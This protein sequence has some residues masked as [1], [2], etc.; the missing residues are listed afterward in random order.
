MLTLLHIYSLIRQRR[1][2]QDSDDH[3]SDIKPWAIFLGRFLSGHRDLYSPHLIQ[4]V[5]S[6]AAAAF[7]I[8]IL[9]FYMFA[10][11]ILPI[12]EN[13]LVPVKAYRTGNQLV[14]NPGMQKPVLSIIAV[15]NS[16]PSSTVPLIYL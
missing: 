4:V 14:D 15:S 1:E 11:I 2:G 9:L 5:R 8:I 13:G 3:L 6:V 12:H 10:I 7:I 16:A